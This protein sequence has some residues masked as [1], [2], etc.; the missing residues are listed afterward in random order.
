MKH[1]NINHPPHYC[2]HS[3]GIEA[4]VISERLSFC[5]GNAFKYLMRCTYKG[6]CLEDLRKAHWYLMRQLE[7][8]DP[9]YQFLIC[10]AHSDDSN[11]SKINQIVQ[12]ESR[13]C[14]HMAAALDA[15]YVAGLMHGG[16]DVVKRALKSVEKIIRIEEARNGQ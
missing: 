9:W 8:R 7:K 6:N 10:D 5:L 16:N 12:Y 3:S 13:Y 11:D 14:G 15:I 4:I 1:D 2:S